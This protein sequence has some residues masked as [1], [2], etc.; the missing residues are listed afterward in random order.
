MSVFVI[1]T[2]EP[3]EEIRFTHDRMPLIMTGDCVDEWIRPD[4]KP[5]KM[6]EAAFTEVVLEKV[7]DNPKERDIQ[8]SML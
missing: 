5:E 7:V 8:M 2:R 1:L 4:A 6:I 3:A